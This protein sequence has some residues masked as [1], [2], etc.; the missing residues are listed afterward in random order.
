MPRATRVVGAF[1]LFFMPLLLPR[2]YL[3]VLS[4]ALALAIGCVG[5]NLLLGNTGLLSFGHAAYFGVGAYTGGFLYFFTPV[6]SFEIYLLSGI[7]AAAGLSTVMGFLCVR[8]TR[9]HFTILTL[10]FAQMVHS[11]FISGMIFEPFGVV[12]K[13]LFLEG[14]GGLY[15]PRLTI[16]GIEFAPE[17]FEMAVYYI[18]LLACLLS[19]WVMWRIINSPF[20]AAL[21]AIRDNDVRAECIG[22]PVRRYRWFAFI[23]S[24]AFTG[25]SGGLFG[26]VYRQV[27]PEQLHWVFSAKMVLATVLGGPWHF[28]GPVVGAFAFTAIQE[29]SLRFTLYHGL[30]LGVLLIAVV[31]LCPGGL[32]GGA[33]VV[34]SRVRGTA[35]V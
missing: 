9:I 23:I 21:R 30:V 20:G 28:W 17:P 15:I 11:V 25:L 27:T 2:Y 14:A 34:I 32:A 35:P 6:T 12:G 8:A 26:Q 33:R 3:L 31:L 7:L 29:V 18:I 24:G 10:A 13:G 5:L 1:L 16:A 4:S 22:I 19:L